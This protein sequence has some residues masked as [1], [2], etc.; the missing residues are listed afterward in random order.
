MASVSGEKDPNSNEGG[1]DS[2]WKEDTMEDLR[3]ELGGPF[4]GEM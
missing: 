4:Q 2:M 1:E 3:C